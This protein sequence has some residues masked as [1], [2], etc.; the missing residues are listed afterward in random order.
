MPDGAEDA[1]RDWRLPGN[2]RLS[3]G[4]SAAPSV[5]DRARASLLSQTI[6]RVIYL[7]RS[8]LTST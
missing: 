2:A 4:R 3:E 5:F 1:T 8:S 7:S 6:Y